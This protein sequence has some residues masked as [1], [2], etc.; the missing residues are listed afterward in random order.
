[1]SLFAVLTTRED[2]LHDSLESTGG[3]LLTST[4]TN[5]HSV[6]LSQP[7]SGYGLT[8][9]QEVKLISQL[10]SVWRIACAE[11]GFDVD[12]EDAANDDAIVADMLT[13]PP[14]VAVRSYGMDCSQIRTGPVEVAS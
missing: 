12:Y 7:G 14:L 13:R 6:G 1:V 3:L 9:A 11:L 10:K 2:A 8:Q 5:G 4:S